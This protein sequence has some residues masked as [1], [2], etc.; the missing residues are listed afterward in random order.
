MKL[1]KLQYGK[2]IPKSTLYDYLLASGRGS[3]QKLNDSRKQLAEEAGIS[4]YTGRGD[5]NDKL[6]AYLRSK[7]SHDLSIS[8]ATDK[9]LRGMSRTISSNQGNSSTSSIKQDKSIPGTFTNLGRSNGSQLTNNSASNSSNISPS[10]PFLK[11]NEG[12]NPE[13]SY[14]DEQ[15]KTQ[16]YGNKTSSSDIMQN[17]LNNNFYFP[18]RRGDNTMHKFVNL[19]AQ[20]AI[21]PLLQAGVS[22]KK[23]LTHDNPDGMDY[24]NTFL[25]ALPGLSK[26]A[27]KVPGNI[28][29]IKGVPSNVMN[30]LNK[31]VGNP[32]MEEDVYST[33]AKG[34]L[35]NIA[36]NSANIINETEGMSPALRN[37]SNNLAKQEIPYI[38]QK[39]A[40]IFGQQILNQSEEA[41]GNKQ[42]QQIYKKLPKKAQSILKK[43]NKNESEYQMGGFKR[44]K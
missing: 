16:F 13:G 32:L 27:G 8:M 23:V 9:I 26:I 7:D 19:M 10:N 31:I 6:Q 12:Y 44:L 35:K 43:L 20:S 5:Q 33:L 29:S 14:L 18:V 36:S 28:K 1:K 40:N 4:N 25:T 41:A 39:Q 11:I 38:N 15:G 42:F 24:F 21:N 3:A 17:K 22:G 37:I 34:Q 2:N 30:S